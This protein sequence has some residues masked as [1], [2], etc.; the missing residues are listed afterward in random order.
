M[1]NDFVHPQSVKTPQ[2]VIHLNHPDKATIHALFECLPMG[3]RMFPEKYQGASYGIV[4]KKGEQEMNFLK[5][6][7]PEVSKENAG[8]ILR[9]NSILIAAALAEYLSLGR[10][11]WFWPS[12]YLKQKQSGLEVGIFYAGGGSFDAYD[13]ESILS[14]YDD[15]LGN[16]FTVRMK[17]FI[18]GLKAQSRRTG[19]TLSPTIGLDI[20]ARSQLGS[21]AFGFLLLDQKVICLK[22][23]VRE[24]DPIWAV[25]RSSGIDTLT[26]LP[27]VPL[28]LPAD[29]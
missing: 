25:I 11:G 23:S 27:S 12:A 18:D 4:V 13:N 26:H 5:Q 16:G 19:I 29:T 10:D 8:T 20:R 9:A 3:L 17:E 22:T 6:Q 21:L 14:T 24:D 1:G 28:E 7:S 2:G 15:A